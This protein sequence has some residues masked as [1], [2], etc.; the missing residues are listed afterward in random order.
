MEEN[1]LLPN[2]VFIITKI[3]HLISIFYDDSEHFF[4]QI[5]EL[6]DAHKIA[7]HKEIMNYFHDLLA[8]KGF[9][10]Y[11]DEFAKKYTLQTEKT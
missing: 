3:E 6:I 5:L 1:P 9:L 11:A 8:K 4:E 2:Q 7:E 10:D